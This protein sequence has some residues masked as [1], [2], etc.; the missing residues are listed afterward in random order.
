MGR[1]FPRIMSIFNTDLINDKEIRISRESYKKGELIRG[2]GEECLQVIKLIKGTVSAKQSF[3]DG[4]N[5]ILRIIHENEYIGLNLI[6]SKSPNYKASFYADEDVEIKLIAKDSLLYLM[7]RDEK[8]LREVLMLISD[9]GINLNEHIKLLNHK[10]IKSKLAY[11]LYS[12]YKK[13]GS[14]FTLDYNKTEL[15]ALLNVERPSLS[16]EL[17]SLIKANI[18]REERNSYTIISPSLLKLLI[19]D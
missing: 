6:F 9:F 18:I 11:L 7:Q 15:A 19:E 16:K 14:S 12:N 5:S 2:E 1:L 8:I 17:N 13:Y 4:H 10:T 3:S